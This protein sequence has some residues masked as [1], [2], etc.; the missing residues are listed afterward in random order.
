MGNLCCFQKN[1]KEFNDHLIKYCY[2]QKC[3]HTY[4]STYEYNRHIVRCNLVN[5]DIK[6]EYLS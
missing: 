6:Y 4:L 1:K 5:D 2:C 3:K